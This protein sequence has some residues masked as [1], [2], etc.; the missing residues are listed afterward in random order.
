MKLRH[1][2]CLATI[3]SLFAFDAIA[4]VGFAPRQG[5]AGALHQ[6]FKLRAPVEK[7][8]P[9]TELK[10]E[11]PAEWK[12][13]GGKVNRVQFDPLWKI[14]LEKDQDDWIKSIAW[15][16]G[17]APDWAFIEFGLAITLPKLTGMQ[18]IKAFQKYSD[19]SVVAWVEDASKK[20]AEKP[21]ARLILS[22]GGGEGEEEGAP[23]A[24]AAGAGGGRP[25]MYGLSGLIGGIVGAGLVLAVRRNKS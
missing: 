19:G 5:K 3:L 18:Q 2:L 7:E 1:F 15:S 21:A 16:G 6:F 13:A 9:T 20:G 12:A 23:R 8:I 4:H 24:A 10:I 14:T 11:I 25:L 22:E 17:S